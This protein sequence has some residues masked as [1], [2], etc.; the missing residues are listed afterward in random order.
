V[1]KTPNPKPS[2]QGVGLISNTLDHVI[3]ALLDVF[4]KSVYGFALLYFRIYFDKK[5]LQAGI[6]KE[7]FDRFSNQTPTPNQHRTPT[8]NQHRTPTPNHDLEAF[9]PRSPLGTLGICSS[10]P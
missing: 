8:P 10:T 6:P 3:M 5:L 4:A 1:I 9:S 7:D 2:T